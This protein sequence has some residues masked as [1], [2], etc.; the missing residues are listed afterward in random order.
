M[1]LQNLFA[2]IR[3]RRSRSAQPFVKTGTKLPKRW[4]ELLDVARQKEVETAPLDGTED[5][6]VHPETGT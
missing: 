5:R 4:Q 6:R 3:I 1:L 2:S